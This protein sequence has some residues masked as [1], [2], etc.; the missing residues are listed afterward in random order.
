M[1]YLIW[2]SLLVSDE[3]GLLSTGWN[4]CLAVTNGHG[5]HMDR[6]QNHVDLIDLFAKCMYWLR[7]ESVVQI[8]LHGNFLAFESLL[9]F[10]FH[11]HWFIVLFDQWSVSLCLHVAVVV[12]VRVYFLVRYVGVLQEVCQDAF[13]ACRLYLSLKRD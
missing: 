13:V 10:F 5:D 6:M 11:T 9:G 2:D 3:T 8:H 1:S 4:V 7:H 12:R